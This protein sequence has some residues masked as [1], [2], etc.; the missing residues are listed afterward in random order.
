VTVRIG[1]ILSAVGGAV[2][3][4]GGVAGLLTPSPPFAG[5][6]VTGSTTPFPPIPPPPSGEGRPLASEQPPADEPPEG[7]ASEPS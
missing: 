1:L 6:E 7:P 2:G 5:P 3:V 4:I